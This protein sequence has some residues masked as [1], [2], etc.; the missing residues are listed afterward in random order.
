MT[1][2]TAASGKQGF[3][4]GQCEHERQNARNLMLKTGHLFLHGWHD[5]GIF[6]PCSFLSAELLQ[7]RLLLFALL[8]HLLIV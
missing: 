4:S 2:G 5:A 6:L 8:F 1:G 3:G 7:R